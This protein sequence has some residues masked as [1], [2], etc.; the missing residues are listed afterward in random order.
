M[1]LTT[2][3]VDTRLAALADPMRAQIVALLARE[4][5]CT[6]HIV[7]DTGA[8]QTTVSHHLKVLR[9]AGLVDSEPFGRFTYYRL[10]AEVLDELQRHLA[11]LAEAARAAAEVRRPC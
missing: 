2:V 3:E 1:S 5:L 8:K 7:A 10:R 6:C 4:R 11:D 9:E